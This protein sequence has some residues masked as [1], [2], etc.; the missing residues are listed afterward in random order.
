[1]RIGRQKEWFMSYNKKYKPLYFEYS[2][3]MVIDVTFGI[4]SSRVDQKKKMMNLQ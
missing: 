4:L 3:L 1:M 2:P